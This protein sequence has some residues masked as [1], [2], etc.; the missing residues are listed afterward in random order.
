MVLRDTL[1]ALLDSRCKDEGITRDT[2]VWRWR[3]QTAPAFRAKEKAKTAGRK[4]TRE[5]TMRRD[6]TLTPEVVRRLFATS[7]VCPYCDRLMRSDD[8]TLDHMVPVSRGGV[9]GI[10]NVTVCCYSCNSRKKDMPFDRWLQRIPPH[11]A[12]RFK[13]VRAA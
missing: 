3:Y 10:G 2:A 5:T 1:T 9:H 8:K 7:S 13:T 6:G 4:A 11:I 12:A